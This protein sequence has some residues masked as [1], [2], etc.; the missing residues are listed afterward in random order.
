VHER[1][2]R[3]HADQRRDLEHAACPDVDAL[4]VGELRAGVAARAG[5]RRATG[6]G[7]TW[8]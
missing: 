5:D 2:A 3:A 7:R 8:P 4:G 6:R 1:P